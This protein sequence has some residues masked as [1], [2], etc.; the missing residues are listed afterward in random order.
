MSKTVKYITHFIKETIFLVP[1]ILLVV[2]FVSAFLSYNNYGYVILGNVSGYS[3]IVDYAL[4]GVFTINKKYCYLTR[5]APIGLVAL[6][7]I[8]IIG[9][10]CNFN[11]YNFWYVVITSFIVFLLSIIFYLNKKI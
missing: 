7:T 9:F 5:L 3:L 6:N 2:S 8:D 10:Y 11:F 1:V 4:I